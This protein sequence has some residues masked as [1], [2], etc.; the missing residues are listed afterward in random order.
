MTLTDYDLKRYHRQILIRGFDETGQLRLK[1]ATVFIA[2]A[3]G[4]GTPVATYLAVAGIGHLV[5]ADMDVVDLSNLNRQILHWDENVDQYKVKSAECKLSA[6]NPS[7]RITPLQVKIDEHNVYA[8]TKGA[9]LIIDAMDNYPT[10]YL[11]NKAA[12]AHNIPFIHASVWGLEGRITTI[13]PGKTPCLEC[14]VPEAPPREVFPVLGAT[15]GV[16]GTLQVTEAIKILTGIGRPLI[17][18][19][20]I[21]DGEYMEF[22]EIAIE[23]DPKCPTCSQKALN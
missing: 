21:Y 6:M 15:P 14:I 4:L 19:M 12:I 13:I 20:L 11:L 10:R 17:N 7:I 9:D 3:G 2:G 1:Q 22:H 18:R 5:I 16:I 8:L 23:P